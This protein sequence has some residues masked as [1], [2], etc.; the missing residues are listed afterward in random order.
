MSY[1]KMD[2]FDLSRLHFEELLKLKEKYKKSVYVFLAICLNNLK[3]Y[4][5][6]ES[7]LEKGCLLYHKFYEAKV[8]PSHAGLPCEDPHQRT[9]V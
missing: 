5:E 1:Y 2:H 9:P 3:R 8:Q 6:A 4:S 7:I